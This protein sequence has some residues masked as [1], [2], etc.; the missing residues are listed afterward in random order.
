MV[1]WHAR[2]SVI[3]LLGVA[4]KVGEQNIAEERRFRAR[5]AGIGPASWSQRV[6]VVDPRPR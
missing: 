2:I 3:R 5:L 6:A 4:I 1:V